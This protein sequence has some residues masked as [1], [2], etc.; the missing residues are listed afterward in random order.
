MAQRSLWTDND[1][2]TD[3]NELS[4]FYSDNELRLSY[5]PRLAA[6]TYGE[7]NASYSFYRYADHSF[8]D[9]DSIEASV[10]AIHVFRSLNDLS[11]WS[12]YNYNSLLTGSGH[13]EFFR[14]HSI[15]LGLYYPIPLGIGNLAYFGYNSEF[16]I[17]SNPDYSSRHEHAFT[18]GYSYSATD[19]IELGTY[20]RFYVHDYH[21]LDRTDLLH[22]VG[23]SLTTRIT[24]RL[25]LLLAGSYSLNDSDARGGDYEV[26]EAGAIIG[27]SYDF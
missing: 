6:N 26:G 16:S 25:D 24:E 4:D 1:E 5:M 22:T 13:D 3:D 21:E 7:F 19:R 11:V 15:E 10:G 17:D 27:F 8:L 9:F 18:I 20:Y 2:L 23:L 14:D 12:R